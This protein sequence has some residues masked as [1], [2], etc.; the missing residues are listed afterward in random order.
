MDLDSVMLSEIRVR[1]LT[2][3]WYNLYLESKKYNKLVNITTTK[4][5]RFIDI[6]NKL[7]VTNGEREG[8]GGRGKAG[9]GD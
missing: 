8:G 7:V 1:K 4:K 2:T 3:V 6:E 5:S 9:V